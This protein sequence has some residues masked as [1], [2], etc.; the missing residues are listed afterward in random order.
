ML[1][2]TNEQIK[3][4]LAK[5]CVCEFVLEASYIVSGAKTFCLKC[6]NIAFKCET[7]NK[8]VGEEYFTIDQRIYCD[9][10]IQI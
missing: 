9:Q 3:L 5:C 4:V 10:C 2:D 7:C 6:Y 8:E 1:D